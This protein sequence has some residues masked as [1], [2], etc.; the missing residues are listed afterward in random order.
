MLALGE[1]LRVKDEEISELMVLSSDLR[2]T[3]T[4]PHYSCADLYN[5]RRGWLVLKV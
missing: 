5:S 2:G 3:P 1:P 4:V